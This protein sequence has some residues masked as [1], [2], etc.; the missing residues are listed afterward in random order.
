MELRG[1]DSS[2]GLV[3]AAVSEHFDCVHASLVFFWRLLRWW[4]G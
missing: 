2:R 4:V 3:A 1:I